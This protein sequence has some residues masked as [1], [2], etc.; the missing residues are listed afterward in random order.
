MDNANTGFKPRLSA[1]VVG[2][3]GALII[4]GRF[5]GMGVE[6]SRDDGMTWNF[7]QIDTAYWANGA[8]FEIEPDVV[9]YIYSG[10]ASL[11]YQIMRLTQTGMEPVKV[12]RFD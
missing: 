6:V 4:G 9:L 7:Y 2:T 3:L 10:R 8:M 1:L 5:P 11:R 12:P